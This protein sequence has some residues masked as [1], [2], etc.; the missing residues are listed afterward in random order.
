MFARLGA[1]GVG[2]GRGGAGGGVAGGARGV[3]WGGGGSPSTGCL[4]TCM[5]VSTEDRWRVCGVWWDCSPATTRDPGP[6]LIFPRRQLCLRKVWHLGHFHSLA[7][8]GTWVIS[9]VWQQ[10][11]PGKEPILCGN[12]PGASCCQSCLK[13]SCLRGDTSGGLGSRVV[14]VG[15]WQAT[16]VNAILSPP[17]W[18]LHSD[19]QR[20]QPL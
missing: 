11:A 19:G 7:T 10:L 2:G 1:G 18:L 12:D 3:R 15:P 9:T 5:Y 17:E 14:V 6:P 13:Q 8:T 4:Y 16:M 20:R